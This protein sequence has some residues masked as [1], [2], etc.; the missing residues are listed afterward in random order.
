[1]PTPLAQSDQEQ[2]MRLSKLSAALG[3]LVEDFDPAIASESDWES[4][5]SALFERDHLLVFR[6]REYSDEEHLAIARAFGPLA[7]EGVGSNTPISYVSNSRPDG[8]LGSIAATWHIDFGFFAH[9]YEAISLYGSE[10]PDDGTQTWFANALAA[11]SDLP[12]PTRQRLQGL[13]ARQVAD[14]TS[15]EA[16][17]GVRIR[18]GRLDESYPHQVRPVLW[19]HWKTGE[20]ILGVWEQQTDAIL[21]LE[22]DESTALI[23]QLFA[24]LYQPAHIYSHDWQQHDLV[25]WDNHALHHSRPDVGVEKPRT[26]RRVSIG[27]TQDYSIFARYLELAAARRAQEMP[28]SSTRAQ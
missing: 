12:E 24:H 26:L 16:E 8:S 13:S 22:P 15:P 3:A 11:A 23:E 18:L 6:G 17:A 27:Q 9:P 5:R 7:G 4:L 21:P 25:I 2:A 28:G 19:P 10:I 14:I 20:P 1:M